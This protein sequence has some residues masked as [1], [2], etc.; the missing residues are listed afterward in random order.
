MKEFTR[1]PDR[2]QAILDHYRPKVAS[3]SDEDL[4]D[5]RRWEDDGN[6]IQTWPGW[7]R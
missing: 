2:V 3:L 1:L 7:L 6:P 4:A 5:L